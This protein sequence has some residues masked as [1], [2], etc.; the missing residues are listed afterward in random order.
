MCSTCNLAEGFIDE[1]KSSTFK[2]YPALY[3]LHYGS[4]SIYGFASYD[5][6]CMQPHKKCANDFS[7]LTAVDSK[8]MGGRPIPAISGLL[9]MSP[10]PYGQSDLFID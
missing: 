6:M 8:M 2:F 4:G 9:G 5:K 1:R 3:D 10:I 7:F